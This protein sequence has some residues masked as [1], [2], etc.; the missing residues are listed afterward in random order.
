MFHV[1]SIW[2]NRSRSHL[3]TRLAL[4]D[5]ASF[6]Y[7]LLPVISVIYVLFVAVDCVSA[8][9]ERWW[10]YLIIRS[11]AVILSYL[12][13]RW[14]RGRTRYGFRVYLA[15]APYVY[16]IQ[17]IMCLENLAFSPYLA[18]VAI[19]MLC[20]AVLFPVRLSVAVVLN[21][22]FIVPLLIWCAL[23]GDLELWQQSLFAFM[24]VGAGVLAVVNSA[25]MGI[26]VVER[27]IAS[28][29]LSRDLGKRH[30][31][32][33]DKAEEL[34][35]RK[36]FEHQFSPQVV[37]AVLKDRSLVQKMDKR[38]IVVVV[39]DVADSTQRA[40]T[41]APDLYKEVIEEVLDVFSAAC[42]KWDITLDKFTGDGVQAFAGAP[43]S[44]SDCLERAV[45]SCLDTIKMLH[46]RLGHL[47]LIW[48]KPL[49]VRF[50]INEGDALVGFIGRGI[51][52]SYTAVGDVVSFTHRLVANPKPWDIAVYSWKRDLSFLGELGQF[53]SKRQA[54]TNLK[55]FVDQRFPCMFLSPKMDQGD[56][57]DVGR[58]ADCS[59]PLVLED[60]PNGLPRV[61]C[62]ACRGAVSNAA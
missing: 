42:L 50:A 10:I 57:V 3:H 52:K 18:G 60:G 43:I 54:V 39:I 56:Q 36:V 49:E 41:L 5:E 14:S 32:I 15:S 27:M 28:E 30:K 20:V 11:V 31:E 34:L 59:T 37:N 33:R 24:V 25:Q 9:T 47:N 17:L 19:V 53:T 46:L 55:G 38:E 51:Y 16:A 35:R 23:T 58:C 44:G 61:S 12:G 29:R 62:P 4:R 40:N 8:K 22:L 1:K 26:D 13:F 7:R 2:S 48:G 6:F 21:L 45:F